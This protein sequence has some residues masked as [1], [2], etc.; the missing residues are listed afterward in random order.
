VGGFFSA[1]GKPG[2]SIIISLTRQIIFLP[3]LL[4]LLP[5]RFGIDGVL[6]AGP[7]SDFAMAVIAIALLCRE[8]RR[9]KALD[10][11]KEET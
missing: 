3:P 8:F 9:L 7:V 10:S 2:N 5:R 1:Q 4:M 6:W 11:E